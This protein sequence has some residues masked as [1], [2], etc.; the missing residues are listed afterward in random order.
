MHERLDR[1]NIDDASLGRAQRSKK[2]MGHVESAVEIDR[3]DVLPV[4][5]DGLG[6]PSERVAAVD[7]G[8]VDQDRDRSDLFVDLPGDR[9]AV[10]APGDIEHKAF[11]LAA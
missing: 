9:D 4:F 2:R 3:H 10:L 8:I 6:I 5:Y 1:S 11:S 7:A